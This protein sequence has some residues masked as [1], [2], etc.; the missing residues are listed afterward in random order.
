MFKNVNFESK[1]K[2]NPTVENKGNLHEIR[3][4]TFQT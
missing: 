1:D 3:L 4:V 2:L